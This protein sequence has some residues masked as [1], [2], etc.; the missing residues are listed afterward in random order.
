MIAY[1]C[2]I[3]NLPTPFVIIT[4]DWLLDYEVAQSV[5]IV[6]FFYTYMYSIE[7][8]YSNFLTIHLLLFNSN[9]LVDISNNITFAHKKLN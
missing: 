5:K 3:K 7:Y 6:L 2:L 8:C 1:I 9:N 4:L